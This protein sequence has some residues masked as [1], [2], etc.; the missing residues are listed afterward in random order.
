MN[1]FLIAAR[2]S[3]ATLPAVISSFIPAMGT[4]SLSLWLCAC[5]FAGPQSIENGREKYNDIIQTTSKDQVFANIVRVYKNEPTLFVDVTEVDASMTLTGTSSL[6]FADL[7]GPQR[8]KTLGVNGTLNG[9]ATYSE[10][11]TVRYFPLAGQA[12]V[13]QLASP[14]TPQSLVYLFGSDWPLI[15]ILS[16]TTDRLTPGFDDY[17]AAVNALAELDDLGAIDLLATVSNDAGEIANAGKNAPPPDT[18]VIAMSDAAPNTVRFGYYRDAMPSD[19][20]RQKNIKAQ[21]LLWQQWL[22]KNGLTD[23]DRETARQLAAK[24]RIWHLWLRLLRIYRDQFIPDPATETDNSDCGGKV[25]SDQGSQQPT[26][27]SKLAA[28]ESRPAAKHNDLPKEQK[29]LAAKAP[30]ERV[31]TYVTHIRS[32]LPTATKGLLSDP[33]QELVDT[34]DSLDR[35]LDQFVSS[36][37]GGVAQKIDALEKHFHC[38]PRR[39]F[40]R[41]TSAVYKMSSDT[42]DRPILRTRSVLGALWASVSTDQGY[43]TFLESND[44]K[45]Q[46]TPNCVDENGNPTADASYYIKLGEWSG[47]EPLNQL[48]NTRVGCMPFAAE[49]DYASLTSRDE[50]DIGHDDLDLEKYLLGARRFLVI[51]YG[52]DSAPSDAYASYRVGDYTYFIAGNDVISQ[53]NFSF[54]ALLLTMQ[55]VASPA[56][57]LTPT[58]NVGAH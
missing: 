26:C 49:S 30:E 54:L 57:S 41:A 19:E 28:R 58:V 8:G 23:N 56:G 55:A 46:L 18:L 20:Q 24:E 48:M 32:G 7:F 14:I 40:L 22:I 1:N 11:P 51:R 15:S 36:T 4:V 29:E 38:I 43:I 5:T 37:P 17:S 6:G 47:A 21:D 39:I 50:L 16:F 3:G 34:L 9:G 42:L 35:N 31:C 53:R 52:K 10:S 2:R 12:L 25:Q 45:T 13:Q 33:Q 27:A 44:T